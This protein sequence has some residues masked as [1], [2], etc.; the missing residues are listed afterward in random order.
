M[1]YEQEPLSRDLW[2]SFKASSIFSPGCC[3]LFE[4]KPLVFAPSETPSSIFTAQDQDALHEDPAACGG[5]V[6]GAHCD[7]RHG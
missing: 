6:A 1:I 3:A 5:T 2:H 7:L 4:A